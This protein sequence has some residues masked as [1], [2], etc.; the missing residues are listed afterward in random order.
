MSKVIKGR[1]LRGV[2]KYITIDGEQK[3]ILMNNLTYYEIEDLYE[4][5]Y[6]IDKG[7]EDIIDEVKRG[8][9]RA[10][11]ALIY[12]GLKVAGNE[13]PEYREWMADF[14]MAALKTVTDKVMESVKDSLPEPDEDD[15][16]NA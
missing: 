16:K 8:K 1:D 9:L 6:G 3:K 10:L 15:G 7:F 11:N 5:E 12:C 2:V 13:M 14:P 4:R